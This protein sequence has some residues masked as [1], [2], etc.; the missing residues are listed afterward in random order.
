MVGTG[1]RR[2]GAGRPRKEVLKARQPGP[3][4]AAEDAFREALPSA[5]KGRDHELEAEGQGS[6]NGLIYCIN[7][8]LGAPTQPIDLEVSRAA[9]RLAAAIGADPEF[10]IRR[11]QQLAAENS[12]AEVTG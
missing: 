1:G 12:G 7:R 5:G 4:R 10:L 9:A 11:A 2:P 8:A 6:E 3:V